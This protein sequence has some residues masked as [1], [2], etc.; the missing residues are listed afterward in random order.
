MGFGEDDTAGVVVLDAK[1]GTPASRLG[2]QRGDM[3]VQINKAEI[4]SAASARKALDA[5]TGPWQI[6]IRRGEDMINLMVR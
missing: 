2:V 1:P 3:I 6:G 4:K 5:S